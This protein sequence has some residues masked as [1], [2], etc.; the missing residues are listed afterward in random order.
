M[1]IRLDGRSIWLVSPLLK[2]MD[3]LRRAMVTSLPMSL[4]PRGC[5]LVPSSSSSDLSAAVPRK[6][7]SDRFPGLDLSTLQGVV[8]GSLPLEGLVSL[9]G[10][11]TLEED[12]QDRGG[13]DRVLRVLYVLHRG[14]SVSPMDVPVTETITESNNQ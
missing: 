14:S 10:C 1:G 11:S 7:R 8:S 13:E 3:R 4:P 12:G 5:T 2:E 9:A 6:L